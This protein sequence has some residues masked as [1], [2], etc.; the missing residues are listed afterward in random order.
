MTRKFLTYMAMAVLCLTACHDKEESEESVMPDRTVLVY[1]SGENNLSDFIQNDLYEMLQAKTDVRRHRLLVYIDDNSSH[2]PY[3]SRVRNGLLT[4]SVSLKDMGI[5]AGDTCSADPT[6]IA[7]IINYAFRK[8]P[9][10][11]NDYGLVLWGHASGWVLED[12]VATKAS[13]RR[14]AYGIDL[15]RNSNNAKASVNMYSLAKALE[16]VPH[17]K[18]IFAD[19]CHFMC[20]ESLYNLRNAADYIIGS[21][22]EIPDIGA[23]YTTV[24]PA[25]FEP[26]TFYTAIINRYYEQRLESNSRVPLSA[27]KAS[28]MTKLAEATLTALQQMKDTLTQTKQ[29][30]TKGL[31]HYYYMPLFIDA[32][33]F[34]LRYASDETYSAWKQAFDNAVVYKK[35][36]TRWLTNASW[37]FNYTDFEMT[38]E[39]FGGVSMFVPQDGV[40]N[41]T[42]Q[43]YNDDIKTTPWYYAAGLYNLGW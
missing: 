34:M 36:A 40:N 9:S 8:Y 31:I 1:M 25:L 35:M 32:N 18:F 24:A 15:G 29:P 14:R 26:D 4:D 6:V 28:E 39:R 10:R 11:E 13:A 42:H 30:N 21:P 7:A 20:L 3:L 16:K 23:P 37:S 38:E 43:L 22:A 33:D 41:S 27:V 5:S 12:S 19:C 17:L 2:T